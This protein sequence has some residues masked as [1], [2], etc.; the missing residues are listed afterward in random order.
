MFS[1]CYRLLAEPYWLLIPAWVVVSLVGLALVRLACSRDEEQLLP[2]A[3]L[4]QRAST[5]L[6]LIGVLMVYAIT[7][8]TVLSGFFQG[9]K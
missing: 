6:T 5:G 3:L 2:L 4:L 7:H 9:L 1:P 8:Q